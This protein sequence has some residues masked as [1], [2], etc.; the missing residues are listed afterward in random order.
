VS[1]Q[2]QASGTLIA[3]SSPPQSNTRCDAL[4]LLHY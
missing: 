2:L 4:D 1:G 3:P